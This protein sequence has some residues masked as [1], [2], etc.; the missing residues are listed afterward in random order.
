[1]EL[2]ITMDSL[3]YFTPRF[4]RPFDSHNDVSL[5]YICHVLF[6]AD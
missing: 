4:V 1:M 5:Y 3:L 6:N 2:I